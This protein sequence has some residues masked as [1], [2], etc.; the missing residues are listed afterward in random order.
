M[1]TEDLIERLAREEESAV[2][3]RSG[4]VAAWTPA[5]LATL[6]IMLVGW[7]LRSGLGLALA[8]PLVLAKIALPMLAAAM[9]LAGGLEL[10]RPEGHATRALPG[11]GALGVAWLG[12][13]TLDLA[14]T[15]PETWDEALR[16]QTRLACLLSILALAVL[17]TAAL[18]A[19][20]RRG[21][22]PRPALSGALA[23]LAGG[24]GAAAIYAFHCPEDAPLF[25]VTW[26]GTGIVIAS[27]AG[28]VLGSRWLRW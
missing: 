7:G 6:V 22:S 12:L 27:A 16:G 10:S 21:A 1:R 18:L 4:V 3:V 23:G 24:A 28:A 2:S 8:D 17:P 20:L 25:Y 5:F 15:P 19:A 14:I 13:L 9:A 26:Y 11:L